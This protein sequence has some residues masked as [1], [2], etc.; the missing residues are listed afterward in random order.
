MNKLSVFLIVLLVSL[1]VGFGMYDF[2]R[3]HERKEITIHTGLLNEARKNP[4][5]AS[6]LFLKRMGIPSEKKES[7]QSLGGIGFPDTNNVIIIT[8][9]RSTLS[10][11]R[12]E[13]LLD[14]VKSGGHLI[15]RSTKDWRYS[16]KDKKEDKI[17]EL[18]SDKESRDPLQRLMGIRTGKRIYLDSNDSMEEEEDEEKGE[19]IISSLLES[20]EKQNNEYKIRLK[21]ASK[22]LNIQSRRF[23]ALELDS[24][25]RKQS[26]QI[27]LANKNFIIRQRIGN[28]MVTLVSDLRFIENYQIEK[29]DHAEIL[30]YLVH[31]LHTDLSQPKQIWLI[32]SDKMPSLWT[33]IWKYAWALN[34][35]LI[36]LFLF[37]ILKVT[38]RFGPLIPKQQENRRSLNEHITSSGNFYWKN[39]KKQLLINS[40]RQ[41]TLKHLARVHP[42]WAQRTEKE[43]LQILSEQIKMPS[44]SLRTLLF[45]PDIEQADD[46][47]RLIQQLEM[48]R[49]SI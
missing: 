10:T 37:W 6:R 21:G 18:L 28:G 1:A 38:R 34:A 3:T 25:Y 47:T 29:S 32:H 23:H 40:S 20:T 12:T 19:N 15:A 27:K 42:G 31:G 7:L 41:S 13:E 9:S 33:L 44:E 22:T 36:I 16:G 49:K 43:Q 48:I 35:S 39:N 8:S 5:Y 4:F 46:F 11:K 24:N 26:E 14:W 17:D 30:W 45:A 2:Y